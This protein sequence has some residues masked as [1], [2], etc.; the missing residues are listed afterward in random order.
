MCSDLQSCPLTFG[1]SNNQRLSCVCCSDSPG[2]SGGGFF[3]LQFKPALSFSHRL[4]SGQLLSCS[5]SVS[6]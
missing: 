4:I 6:R 3:V 1:N 5:V 2:D